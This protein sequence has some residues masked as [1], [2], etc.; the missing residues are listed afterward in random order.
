MSRRQHFGPVLP[1]PPLLLV[2]H[3]RKVGCARARNIHTQ[4]VRESAITVTPNGGEAEGGKEGGGHCCH[5]VHLRRLI[6]S[7]KL[8]SSNSCRKYSACGYS[9]NFEY[10]ATRQ[11][12]RYCRYAMKSALSR[13]SFCARTAP[14]TARQRSDTARQSAIQSFSQSFSQPPPFFLVSER[15]RSPATYS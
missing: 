10:G 7:R 5:Y 8:G 14:H 11:Y 4:T 15:R 12:C 6:A 2:H 1:Q 9:T 3:D 13:Y